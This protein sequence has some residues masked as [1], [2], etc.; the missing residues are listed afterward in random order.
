MPV[1]AN[2]PFTVE[3]LQKFDAKLSEAL[4]LSAGQTLTVLVEMSPIPAMEEL[5]PLGLASTGNLVIGRVTAEQ[6]QRIAA[7]EDVRS[8]S[9]FGESYLR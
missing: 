9:L 4:D 3:E 1:L 2:V 6:L 5:L 8:V 7:R